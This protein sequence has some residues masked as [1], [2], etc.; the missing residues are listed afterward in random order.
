[1]NPIDRS[2]RH[3]LSRRSFLA[4]VAPISLG[5]YSL[6][7]SG[8]AFARMGRGGVAQGVLGPGYLPLTNTPAAF[9]PMAQIYPRPDSETNSFAR[10]HRW[11]FNSTTDTADDSICLGVQFGRFPYVFELKAGPPGMYIEATTWNTAWNT[12]TDAHVNGYGRLRWKPQAAIAA[13]ASY[14]PAS[15]NVWVRVYDQDYQTNPN[16]YIDIKF[17][18]WTEGNYSKTGGV[19]NGPQGFIFVDNVNGSDGNTA[20]TKAL[21]LASLGVTGGAITTLGVTTQPTGTLP[22]GTYNGVAL[23]NDVSNGVGATADLTFSGGSLTSAAIFNTGAGY[24]VNDTLFVPSGLVSSL[25]I[26]TQPTGTLTNDTY[27]AVALS[28]SSGGSGQSGGVQVTFVVSGGTITSVTPTTSSGG[29]TASQALYIPKA[30]IPGA[31]SSCALSVGAVTG[32]GVLTVTGATAAG[33]NGGA[34]G[35]SRAVS[36]TMSQYPQAL[37]YVRGSTTPYEVPLFVDQDCAFSESCF[38]IQTTTAP[39]AIMAFP[40]DANPVATNAN[41]PS[42][43]HIVTNQSC[44]DLFIKDIQPQGYSS[45]STTLAGYKLINMNG[46]GSSTY[47]ITLDGL[48][49]NNGG[50]GGTWSN[51]GSDNSTMIWCTGASSI[52]E[53]LFVTGCQDLNRQSGTPGNNY[54]GCDVYSMTNVLIQYCA[55]INASGSCDAAWYLKS[56][57]TNGEVRCCVAQYTSCL[58]AFSLGQ[59]VQTGETLAYCESR[60]NLGINVNEIYAPAV[61][62]QGP[63]SIVRNSIYN[64]GNVSG[65]VSF[66]SA[67]VNFGY[68]AINTTRTLAVPSGG[69]ANMTSTGNVVKSNVLNSSGLLT[70][71]YA[72]PVSGGGVL[73]TVGAKISALT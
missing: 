62:G 13:P 48:V 12:G 5:A 22:S 44:S 65:L 11:Y 1:M 21:P 30:S 16:S 52:G 34:Y 64:A 58:Y 59:T 39:C 73:G 14:P 25:S 28:T 57:I 8:E 49:Y 10:H 19:A 26:T 70:G 51:A 69:N 31:T 7:C 29:Y 18:V 35:S 23:T 56:D 41:H 67:V 17:S 50:Y 9:Q 68:N 53:Y 61:S 72:N 63:Y 47:R 66:G 36:A 27:T 42:T 54:G 46:K 6:I 40:G 2:V 24:A 3:V 43:H 33:T 45:N 15:P 32:T 37:C 60:Y 4:G 38:E 71:T 20:A 55:G